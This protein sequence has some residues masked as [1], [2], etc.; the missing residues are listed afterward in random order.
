ML[1][2]TD[3]NRAKQNQH[4]TQ[5]RNKQYYLIYPPKQ[6][7]YQSIYILS[8]ENN[9]ISLISPTIQRVGGAAYIQIKA[10]NPKYPEIPS[11]VII[12]L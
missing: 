3:K 1:Y 10:H 2:G 12:L 6:P 4:Q 11:K 9:F 8:Y 5:T 7:Y